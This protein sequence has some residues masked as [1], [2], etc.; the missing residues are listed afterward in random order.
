MITMID[1]IYDRNYQAS[2]RELNASLTRSLSSFGKAFREAFE[3]LV[4]IE[5]QSPWTA[6]SRRARCN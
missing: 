2:R 1:E 6:S 5:Y 4:G 3:V